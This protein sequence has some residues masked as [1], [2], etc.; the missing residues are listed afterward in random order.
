MTAASDWAGLVALVDLPRNWHASFP[1]RNLAP[2]GDPAMSSRKM[3]G[4]DHQ[5]WWTAR[6][7]DKTS[8]PAEKEGVLSVA[9][10]L[11]RARIPAPAT[12][13]PVDLET[14]YRASGQV[15]VWPG[16]PGATGQFIRSLPNTGTSS[17]KGIVG[18]KNRRCR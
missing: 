9:S 11:R 8:P 12:S 7:S 17:I 16:N 4:I 6:Q 1:P 10:D 14:S 13:C 18:M 5:Y 15:T 3:K 2:T